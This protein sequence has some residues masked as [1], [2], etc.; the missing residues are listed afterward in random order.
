MGVNV[1]QEFLSLASTF[2][3]CKVS[4][5]PFTYL[6]LPVGASP[7]RVSTWEP[8]LE[9]LRKRLGVWSNKYVSFGGRIVLLNAVL[10]AIL[11][12]YLSYLKIPVQVWKKVR[13]IQREFLW[14]ARTGHKKI[15]WINWDTICL[16]KKKGGL[17]VRD[18]RAVNI[19][20]LTKW[21][22]KLLDNSQAVWKEVLV[23]KYGANVVGRLE[24][25]DNVKPWYS[26]LWWKDVC[27]IG[28]NLGINW[29]SQNV[30]KKV[31]N[32]AQTNFWVDRWIGEI[33]LKDRFP[34]LFSI[35]RQKEATVAEIWDPGSADFKWRLLWRRRLFVW[36]ENVVEELKGVLNEAIVS[37]E[38][39]CWSWRPDKN[40][41]FT[42]SSTYKL[43]TQLQHS[44]VQQT[45]WHA[46]IYQNLWKSPA[47]SKVSSFVWQLLHDRVPTRNNLVIRQV[48]TEGL[49]SVCPLCGLE[50]ET[51][52]HLFMYCNVATKVWQDIFLWLNIPFDRPHSVFSILNC[53]LAAG[54]PKGNKGRM[55]IACA[56]FWMLWKFRNQAVFDNGSSSVVELVEGVKVASWKWWLARTKNS[57]CLFYEWNQ[58][59]GLC[60][61]V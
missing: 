34:R 30:S 29:F 1:S 35:S 15:S 54:N 13:R 45:Q 7:R 4:S 43:I 49:E 60:L 55:M 22:W 44:P 53:V 3:N 12:F 17:G 40:N 8:L 31:G 36:E 59:P 57:Q 50:L 27:S 38:V 42:V 18:I 24:L 20:L 25:G 47:P 56:V 52:E 37:A 32:G 58:E 61:I 11:V 21:R 51:S 5:I 26:S 28:E 46:Y 39:D 2:L 33:P 16:P 6:G 19:S 48:I 23:S 9:S 14:G 41:I 10:N